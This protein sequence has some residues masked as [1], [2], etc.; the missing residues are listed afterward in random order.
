MPNLVGIW[1]PGF[2]GSGMVAGSNNCRTGGGKY[3]V[4]CGDRRFRMATRPCLSLHRSAKSL[5]NSDVIILF[6][7]TVSSTHS[8][9]RNRT[10]CAY[11]SLLIFVQYDFIDLTMVLRSWMK[12]DK[13][14][15][16]FNVYV[17][18]STFAVP[19]ETQY[20][21]TFDPGFVWIMRMT[22]SES[23]VIISCLS[24]TSASLTE[25]NDKYD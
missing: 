1:T 17:L 8:K 7:R 22:C 16:N 11:S 21:P 6:I 2:S 25:K 15:W 3:R 9:M 13:S 10:K 24:L 23:L 5:L 19:Y 20:Q 4:S 18:F 14:K 12:L